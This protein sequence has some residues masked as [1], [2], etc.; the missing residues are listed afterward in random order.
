MPAT[1]TRRRWDAVRVQLVSDIRVAHPQSPEFAYPLDRLLAHRARTP[2]PDTLRPLHRERVLRSLTDQ[3][4][5]ELREGRE[6]RRHHLPG[7]SRRIDAEV[8]RD[9]IPATLASPLHERREVEERARE[10]VELGD[11]QSLAMP[12][13]T[14]SRAR[15]SPLRPFMDFPLT[16][17]SSKTWTSSQPRRSASA[18]S[19]RAAP[20]APL[21]SPPARSSRPGCSRLRR[22]LALTWSSPPCPAPERSRAAGA[23]TLLF[24]LEVYHAVT[25]NGR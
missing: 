18:R 16:P 15:W 21:P 20:R 24:P 25:E 3:P 10:P 12:A 11:D 4:A 2:E 17:A 9:Q 19:R 5:L 13:S 14:A 6:D 8:E 22:T 23:F 7:R 1:S